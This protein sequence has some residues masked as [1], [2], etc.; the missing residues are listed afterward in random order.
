MD[1]ISCTPDQ[2]SVRRRGEETH[3]GEVDGTLI[4]D[5]LTDPN[6]FLPSHHEPE[7]TIDLVDFGLHTLIERHEHTRGLVEEEE[8]AGDCESESRGFGNRVDALRSFD[9]VDRRG[10]CDWLASGGRGD[11]CSG[12]EGRGELVAAVV[13]VV[14]FVLS[15][16]CRGRRVE[17]EIPLLI[18]IL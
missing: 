9:F 18:L 3:I 6:P 11:N 7:S 2:Y 12:R 4:Q 15:S 1:V 13:S 8:L 10:R 14:L 5:A 16:R 17:R